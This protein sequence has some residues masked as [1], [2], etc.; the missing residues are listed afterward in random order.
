MQRA[1]HAFD[2]LA[3]TDVCLS[4]GGDM[5]CRVA[6]PEGAPWRIGIEDP[7]DPSRV[8][9]VVPLRNGGGRHVG[10]DAPGRPHR[11]RAHGGGAPRRQVGHRRGGRPDLGRHRRDRGLR[12]GR[13]RPA[14]ARVAAGPTRRG[15]RGRR[16]R[17]GLRDGLSGA[18]TRAGSPPRP[19]GPQRSWRAPRRDHDRRIR[20]G[21]R[22]GCPPGTSRRTC[23]TSR[24]APT[25]PPRPPAR[26]AQKS[27]LEVLTRGGAPNGW[28][29]PP[30]LNSLR[31][32]TSSRGGWGNSDVTP[33]ALR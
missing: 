8:V 9:A 20:C 1:A 32:P 16:V 31:A 12:T 7:R 11:R 15:R 22:A 13:P 25:A 5:V 33:G 3:D 14:V 21:H 18:R 28:F 27:H 17:A 26:P 24:I 19:S 23:R 2:V 29:G 30:R 4:A 10:T 6:D